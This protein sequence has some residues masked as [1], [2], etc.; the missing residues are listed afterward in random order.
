MSNTDWELGLQ[1]LSHLELQ[2]PHHPD[3]L[4]SQIQEH[5]LK[6]DQFQNSAKVDAMVFDGDVMDG[7]SDQAKDE[8]RNPK[9]NEGEARNGLDDEKY[10]KETLK[11]KH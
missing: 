8:K 1:H 11:L 6:K 10:N 7:F 5:D 9:K 3:L 4:Q 2:H